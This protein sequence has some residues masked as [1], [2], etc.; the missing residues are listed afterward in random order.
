M[1]DLLIHVDIFRWKKFL[2]AEKTMFQKPITQTTIL[3]AEIGGDGG[4]DHDGGFVNDL[5]RFRSTVAV[6][7]SVVVVSRLQYN[8]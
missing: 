8:T 1:L 4:G 3:T 2:S 6:G 7:E 5:M